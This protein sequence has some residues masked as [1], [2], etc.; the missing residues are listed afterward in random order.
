MS[1]IASTDSAVTAA[2]REVDRA[3]LAV[4]KALQEKRREAAAM[5]RLIEVA[6][7]SGKGR[8]IDVQA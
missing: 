7:T 1:A 4:S 6:D 5:V 3:T 2:V 8:H